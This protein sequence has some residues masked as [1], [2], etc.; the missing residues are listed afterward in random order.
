MS[1]FIGDTHLL[2]DTVEVEKLGAGLPSPIPG[3][4]PATSNA[5]VV[6]CYLIARCERGSQCET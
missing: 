5:F 3:L 1:W 6:L 4:P 2:L